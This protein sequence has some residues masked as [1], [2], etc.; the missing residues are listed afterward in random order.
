VD[1]KAMTV[2]RTLLL[3]LLATVTLTAQTPATRVL[4]R[5]DF[6]TPT[7]VLM[8]TPP[9]PGGFDYG[10]GLAIRQ[11]PA[12]GWHAGHW[13][14]YTSTHPED[15][16]EFELPANFS[17]TAT[18]VQKIGA[19]PH[20]GQFGGDSLFFDEP[21]NRLCVSSGSQYTNKTGQNTLACAE[22]DAATGRL[23]TVVNAAGETVTPRRA[24]GFQ[25]CKASGACTPRPDRM[26]QSGIFRIRNEAIAQKLKGHYVAG[27]GGTYSI[28]SNGVSMGLAGCAFDLPAQSYIGRITCTPLLGYPS[29]NA[30]G[31]GRTYMNRDP[32]YIQVLGWDD[33]PQRGTAA[34][35][36]YG[37]GKFAPEDGLNGMAADIIDLPGAAAFVGF[38]EI[39]RGCIGYGD[40][41]YNRPPVVKEGPPVKPKG[42]DLA[43]GVVTIPAAWDTG[44]PVNVKANVGGLIGGKF[45]YYVYFLRKVGDH[46]YTFHPTRADAENNTAQKMLTR[47][48]TAAVQPVSYCQS[49]AKPYPYPKGA[50]GSQGARHVLYFYNLDDLAAVARREKAQNAVQP[51]SFAN[52][53]LTGVKYPVPGMNGRRVT[54]AQWIPEL[55]TFAVS[56][57]D[58]T[59]TKQGRKIWFYPVG[60][61]QQLPPPKPTGLS[62]EEAR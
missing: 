17:G 12:G 15:L 21:S 34:L 62:L 19:I 22:L 9:L 35:A 13:H 47:K 5:A 16:L 33:N 40:N 58:I 60:A 31:V 57:S 49:P 43:T 56:V 41:Y 26:T 7:A 46:A 8:E 51:T 32:D 52:L 20:Y 3:A 24:W 50:V 6:G 1:I 37:T 11:M 48:L 53:E 18:F 59:S 27:F 54:G 42:T 61:G 29:S 39:Q 36:K 44:Q 14:V 28:I 2:L 25:V 4:T 30:R 10:Q 38:A 55:S 23:R 45:E